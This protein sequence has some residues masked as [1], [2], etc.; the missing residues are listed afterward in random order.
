MN[1][2]WVDNLMYN[3]KRL[4]GQQILICLPTESFR[5]VTTNRF[6]ATIETISIPKAIVLDRE[7]SRDFVYDLNYIAANKNFT[8]GAF[9]DTFDRSVIIHKKDLPVNFDPS[10]GYYV[11]INGNNYEIQKYNDFD[12]Y[13]RVLSLNVKGISGNRVEGDD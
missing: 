9:F 10:L 7:A 11:T 2:R 12:S 3:L 13:G 5:D 6:E 8:L 1:A 4:Y